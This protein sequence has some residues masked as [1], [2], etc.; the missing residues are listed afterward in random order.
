MSMEGWTWMTC[1]F[2]VPWDELRPFGFCEE[3][4]IKHGRPE[5][6]EDE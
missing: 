3:C 4:W 1:C 2:L 5:S 6:M